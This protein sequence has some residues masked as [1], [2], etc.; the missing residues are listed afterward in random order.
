MLALAA[1][2]CEKEDRQFDSDPLSANTVAAARVGPPVVGMLPA[3]MPATAPSP[4]PVR[5]DFE[6]NAYALSEGKRL[7]EAFNCVGCHAHGGGGIGPALMDNEWIHGSEPEIIFGG[8]VD[9][10]PNGMP[11]LR[12]KIADYQ[13]WQ[14]VAYVR[15][16]AGISSSRDAAPGRDDHMHAARPANSASKGHP[17]TSM[18]PLRDLNKQQDAEFARMGGLNGV[19]SQ[20]TARQGTTRPASTQPTRANSRP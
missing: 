6:S 18:A 16:L 5:H 10:W 9:G 1:L 12:G 3:T 4:R 15:S 17:R 11:A 20:F 2:S 13:V 14:I 8:I 19:I 7:Y